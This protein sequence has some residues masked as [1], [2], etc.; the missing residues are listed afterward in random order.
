MVPEPVVIGN[1]D[2]VQPYAL[3]L[4]DKLIRVNET[5]NRSRVGVSMNIYYQR[6]PLA[7]LIS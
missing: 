2:S 5:V 1:A 6:R 3:S 7:V 4:L